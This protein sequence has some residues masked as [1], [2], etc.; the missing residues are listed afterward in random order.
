MGDSFIEKRKENW[1]RL[2]ELIQQTR[3]VRGLRNLTRDEVREL[4][5][6]YRR[7]ASDL[8]IARVES[9]DLRL[10]S[11]LNNL[12]IRAH[13]MIYRTESNGWRA[14]AD[15]YR[16]DFPAIFRQTARYTV[17]AFLIFAAISI[18][19][20]VATW[21]NEDFADFAGVSPPLLRAIKENREWWRILNEQAPKGAVD[22]FT[23]NIRVGILAFAFSIF[24]IVGT[25][26]ILMSNALLFGA[27]NAL[28]IKYGMTRAL[29]AFVAG[30][31][32]LEF[33][34][35]FIACGAGLMIGLAVLVPGERTRREALI[36][37]G[38]LAIKLMAG[39]FPMFVIAGCI[40]AFIS[41]LPIHYLYR[42]SVSAATA[43]G[44][45]AYL[46]KPGRRRDTELNAG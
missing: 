43:V 44:L 45:A 3:S 10:I 42:F 30:H 33:M 26:Q 27:V 8:A 39:C 14:I 16:Y 19:S 18:C 24:P 17:G 41:P 31:G 35:I 15:F 1:K 2:E 23:N 38:N 4:G 29:W 12:V 9:R 46:L 5:R 6:S 40:E 20:F 37:R 7:A 28:I 22:I 36:E 25:M 34:A 21:Q 13:G 11:Y 32:V